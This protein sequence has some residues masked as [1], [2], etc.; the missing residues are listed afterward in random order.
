M[1][2]RVVNGQVGECARMSQQWTVMYS[3][4]VAKLEDQLVA[5]V[6]DLDR[7]GMLGPP[8]PPL[9]ANDNVAVK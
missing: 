8:A 5:L 9:P 7:N 6:E 4:D 2:K 1:S 3:G